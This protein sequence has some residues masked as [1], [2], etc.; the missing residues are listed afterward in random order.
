MFCSVDVFKLATVFEVSLFLVHYLGVTTYPPETSSTSSSFSYIESESTEYSISTKSS[1]PEGGIF[2]I[3]KQSKST[4]QEG[5][6]TKTRIGLI[7]GG[8]AFLV[9]LTVGAT[10]A[11]LR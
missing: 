3:D 2:P 5:W 6:L 1:P 7:T 11:F 4:P 9:L 8:F 10:I